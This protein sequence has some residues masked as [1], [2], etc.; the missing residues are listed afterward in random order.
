MKLY[1]LYII[2]NI[3]CVC[4]AIPELYKERDNNSTISWTTLLLQKFPVYH[5]YAHFPALLSIDFKNTTT[6]I[7]TLNTEY[8]FYEHLYNM[9][10]PHTIS[11]GTLV[12]LFGV[13]FNPILLPISGIYFG[14][15]IVIQLYAFHYRN[16][17]KYMLMY[18]TFDV[19][20]YKDSWWITY[21]YIVPQIPSIILIIMLYVIFVMY[22]KSYFKMNIWIMILLL[23]G[24]LFIYSFINIVH[25]SEVLLHK[26]I[27]QTFTEIQWTCNIYKFGFWE[28]IKFRLTSGFKH[29]HVNWETGYIVNDKYCSKLYLS[30]YK[31]RESIIELLLRTWTKGILC[32]LREIVV[33]IATY[34]FISKILF[35]VCV[36]V[37]M[38]NVHI[39]I[40]IMQICI[41]CCSKHIYSQNPLNLQEEKCSGVSILSKKKDE[42]IIYQE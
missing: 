40:S 32:I 12:M 17:Y 3:V 5:F 2:L 6:N 4:G 28:Y 24:T 41:R 26:D 8:T 35:C 29:N 22:V 1:I 21:F 37:A 34:T 33:E 39:L 14:S 7:S 18:N 11:S 31:K 23:Y 15:N 9:T 42:L 10:V 13:Y 38:L 36:I 30:I 19:Y 25:E 20:K 16:H 27:E